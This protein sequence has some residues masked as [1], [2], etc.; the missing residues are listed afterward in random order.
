MS[1]V[2][3]SELFG[4]LSQGSLLLLP[5]ARAARDL[6]A[7]FDAHQRELGLPAWEPARALSWSQWTNS[8]W[9]ELIVQGS[10]ERLL[11]NAAQEHSLWRQIIA[12]DTANRSIGSLDSLA[13]LAQ[14]AWRVAADHDAT[15]KLG[16]F[17]A[18]HDSRIFAAWAESFERLCADRGYVSACR[19]SAALQEHARRGLLAIPASLD[20]IGFRHF[21]PSQQALLDV[22]RRS[23]TT[24]YPLQ[25]K[26]AETFERIVAS[27]AS[28]TASDECL[29]AVRWI[30]QFLESRRTSQPAARAALLVP[31]VAEERA[32]LEGILREVLAPELESI[33]A[34]LS[35]APWEF[36]GGVPLPS[37]AIVVDALEIIRW[38][39]GA[40]PIE[41]VSS[42]MLSPYLGTNGSDDAAHN[43]AARF[44]VIRLRRTF[45]LRSE[46][47][48]PDLLDLV[49]QS[50]EDSSAPSIAPW[51]RNVHEF[52]KNSGDQKRAR[53]FSECMELVRGI[54]LAANW[55][56]TRALDT[57]EF[58]ATRAWD[59][60]LDLVST[61]DFGGRRVA[62]VSAVS[63]LELQVKRAISQIPSNDA[64]LQVMSI[65]EAEGSTF[66]A[67]VFLHVT[68]ANWPAPERVNPLLPWGLQRSLQMPGTD[69]ALSASRS[70]AVTDDLLRTCSNVLFSYAT[71]DAN[72]KLRPSSILSE[73]GI[74]A[75]NSAE[76]QLPAPYFEPVNSEWLVDDGELPALPS[77]EV[78]GGASVLKLQAACGF[79]AFAELRLRA[80][81]PKSGTLGL[82]AGE[83]GNLLHRALQNFWRETITQDNLR[84]MS[85]EE[86]DQTLTRAIDQSFP[87]RLEANEGWD[88][89]Y[90]WLL[91][92]RLRSVLLQWLDQE[93]LRG[94]FV[95]SDVE[96]KEL[97]TVGPLTLEVRVDRV[98]SVKDGL[99]F[100]DYK[101]G[102]SVDPKQWS[103][104]RPDD[105]QLP[106][107]TL[108]AEAEELKG[109][110]FAK[111]RAGREMKW[112]GYQSEEGILPHSRT[113]VRDM[114][115]LA[116]EW[117][118]V[119]TSLAE[120]FAAGKA[121]VRPKSF[122]VNCGRCAQRLLC[123]I[124]PSSLQELAE[125]AGEEAEDEFD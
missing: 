68:D 109:V 15:Q 61:L 12:G 75:L 81:E 62:F 96:R 70:R 19:L 58:E 54:L 87:S 93:L 92:R 59:S 104:P 95:V 99:F 63:A 107:Y 9:S 94:P 122:E 21:L 66:D 41:R 110:A 91:K 113:N 2:T 50:E 34:D 1:P 17:A 115:L 119:L 102:T 85:P 8:L 22:F 26:A 116:E 18:S 32:Q 67:A 13:E 111:V 10:E 20:L 29:L 82:D 27:V 16:T 73:L 65:A 40:L 106:L 37:L 88:R 3:L 44:D 45:L 123:R 60:V 47:N 98:D 77:Y 84:S 46:I 52:L 49:Q 71:E 4:V 57:A 24:I 120:D 117:R 112:Q 89:A 7:R 90:L 108:L 72:G 11:L 14:S 78:S 23:G 64:P 56:G 55:P 30:R 42:L 35:S 38:T 36:S 33:D 53:S 100:V 43:E 76:L 31:N 86:R 105:P 121:N 28:P 125:E 114:A 5:H 101:T 118:C 74:K 48:I 83:T 103:G 97:V 124:D 79:L 69:P 39:Q 51:V 6:R 80:T 25:L